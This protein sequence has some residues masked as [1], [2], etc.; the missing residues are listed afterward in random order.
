LSNSDEWWTTIIQKHI[1]DL[2][3]FQFKTT[4]AIGSSGLN[5]YNAFFIGK[6]PVT[7]SKSGDKSQTLTTDEPILI[8]Q[9]SNGYNLL[10][11]KSVTLDS[12]N[13]QITCEN[14]AMETFNNGDEWMDS[15][16][17][18]IYII[19]GKVLNFDKLILDTRTRKTIVKNSS[20]TLTFN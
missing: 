1:I 6:N 2:K 12:E 10:I 11:A 7:N 4:I 8:L 16:Q 17:Y 5:G 14:G 13:Y 3:Q 9:H 20:G 19:L 18:A 15:P